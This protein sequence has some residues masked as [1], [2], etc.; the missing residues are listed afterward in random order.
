MP[1]FDGFRPYTFLYK[2]RSGPF[3]GGGPSQLLVKAASSK[4]SELPIEAVNEQDALS[5]LFDNFIAS[6][7]VPVA[8]LLDEIAQIWTIF[9]TGRCSTL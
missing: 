2:P 1:I 9:D 4:L 3:S 8:P 6:R 5:F 7:T